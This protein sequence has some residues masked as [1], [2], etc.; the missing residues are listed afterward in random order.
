VARALLRIFG[1]HGMTVSNPKHLVGAFNWHLM[2]CVFLFPDE[3]F[4]AGD[5][6]HVGQ[7]NALITEGVIAIEAK[8]R[9]L[10]A[11]PNR[12]HIMMASNEEWV[13]PAAFDA[14]RYFVLDVADSVVG[15]KVYFEELNMQMEVGGYEA[16]LY[17]LLHY[18]LTG[19]DYRNPPHTEALQEQ[20]K[21]SLP[22]TEA[23]WLDVLHRG[24]V[25]ESRI[26]LQDFFGAW[27]PTVS[28]D[29]L[30]KSYEA[31]AQKRR[32]RH[33][34]S[35]ETLGRKLKNDFGCKEAKP[36]D[37]VVGEQIVDVTKDFGIVRTAEVI[38][39]DRA[40][41]YKLG[42]LDLA[43]AAFEEKTGLTIEWGV[44][45]DYVEEQEDA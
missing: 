15:N 43:R 11:A 4:F 17:D 19:F 24:Y 41:G 33:P 42:K 38:R 6:A 44:P 5:R 2:D 20:K 34:L 21:L 7:L 13:V 37:A 16:M 30:Q 45:D 32:E 27:M 40:Q 36:Y 35:R 23:W 8:G 39:K 29:L 10:I 3:A 26:G 14:R 18:D 22:T 12:L 25:Y 28:T 1:Q 9:D 31:F